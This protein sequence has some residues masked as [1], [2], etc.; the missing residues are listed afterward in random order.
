[1]TAERA[2]ARPEREETS[3]AFSAGAP[4]FFRSAVFKI[5]AVTVL[6]P[7]LIAAI[8]Y[9]VFA[10]DQYV[11]ET[12]F[13]IYSEEK[14]A[15][16][17]LGGLSAGYGLV[18]TKTKKD[19]LV[20]KEFIESVALLEKLDERLRLKELYR[21]KEA[22]FW[23]RLPSGDLGR[24]E[25]LDYYQ[26]MMRIVLNQDAGI[27]ALSVNAFTPEDA[28]DIAR[29]ILDITELFINDMMTRIRHDDLNFA[30]KQL[31]DS[32]NRV[33]AAL[34]EISAFRK[35]NKSLDPEKTGAGLFS[36]VQDLEAEKIK[37]SA[38][39]SAMRATLREGAHEIQQLKH[40]IAALTE[41]ID[42]QRQTLV[43]TGAEPLSDVMQQYQKL[44]MR[45]DFAVKRY[46][47]AL[48]SFENALVNSNRKSKYVVRVIE[49]AVPDRAAEPERF[50]ETLSVFLLSLLATAIG[51]LLYA[52]VRDHMVI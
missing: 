38:E 23:A 44:L 10:A 43:G 48:N 34:E 13:S 50:K 29:N 47:I 11:S 32:E 46:E 36:L 19:L 33:V 17:L 28:A 15:D 5:L 27:I 14:P 42:K 2:T 12:S 21:R 3:A 8:Y 1:M 30:A 35:N 22:D 7:T 40:K 9:G 52:G 41:E 49:P 18:D 31:Q 6:L 25:F 39:L 26:G 20:V 24:R 45:Q 4:A 16:A 37:T 51:G